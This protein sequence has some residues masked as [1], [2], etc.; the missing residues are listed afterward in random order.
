VKA[1]RSAGMLAAVLL[2]ALLLNA[3][4]PKGVQREFAFPITAV[5]AALKQLDAY[6][7]A[8]LPT[9]DGFITTE[10]AQL[11]HYQRPYYEYKINLT[12]AGATRTEV[13][14]RAEVSAW[15]EDPQGQQSG[16]QT[17]ESNGRLESDL[18]DRL[19][20][21]LT[22]NQSKLLADPS[23]LVKQIAAVRQQESDAQ[24]QIAELEQQLQQAQT[25]SEHADRAELVT[26]ARGRIA[27]LK[28][29]EEHSPVVLHAQAQDEFEVLEHRGAWLR[30]NLQDASSGWV[31]SSDV[32][33]AAAGDDSSSSADSAGFMVIRK[34][35][36]PFSGDWPRLKGKPTLYVWARPLGSSL[37]A[38]PAGRLHF[39]QALFRQRYLEAVHSPQRSFEGVVVIFLDAGGG[40][41]AANL[42]DIGQWVDE[43]IKEPVF[44]ARCSFDPRSEFFAAAR[45]EAQ[46][47]R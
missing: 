24:Q 21:Y 11:P 4:T 40:V 19:G 34:N 20:E 1:M 39:A 9:L 45:A 27:V 17:L 42:E 43:T 3:Q 35:V 6:T 37:N 38:S 30:V 15:F 14:V 16:Y 18:L 33:P 25:G 41:A 13:Q 22:T 12:M 36:M 10:R 5:E 8:R 29:P 32:R 31:R 28:S 47:K 26:V 46:R 7:G 2:L 44:Q 23:A